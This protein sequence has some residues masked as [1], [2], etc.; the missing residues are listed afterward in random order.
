MSSSELDD[1][2]SIVVGNY[3]CEKNFAPVLE[4][5]RSQKKSKIADDVPLLLFRLRNLLI[6]L[7]EE[8]N[9]TVS[10]GLLEVTEAL[11]PFFSGT[12]FGSVV[13][14]LLYRLRLLDLY[15]ILNVGE[16]EAMHLL[17]LSN[18]IDH[19]FPE[20]FNSPLQK[21]RDQY[22][23]ARK[24]WLNLV[25]SNFALNDFLKNDHD[26]RLKKSVI[27]IRELGSKFIEDAFK[28][29][30]EEEISEKKFDFS[31]HP[32]WKNFVECSESENIDV[33]DVQI[34]LNFVE[35]IEFKRIKKQFDEIEGVPIQDSV[36]IDF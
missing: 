27:D 17:V 16:V 4:Y 24:F 26:P 11:I 5:L 34:L 36:Q 31:S 1:S 13:K 2:I 21:T 25:N 8:Q 9:C 33:D 20:D 30:R 28:W 12:N 19:H 22:A 35:F 3:A 23:F 7:E 32:M 15:V 29:F 6:Q 10:K 18:A 14:T